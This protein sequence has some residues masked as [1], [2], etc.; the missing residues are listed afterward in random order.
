MSISR[1]STTG[2]AALVLLPD[3]WEPLSYELVLPL[4][5]PK[6]PMPGTAAGLRIDDI[7]K[8]AAIKTEDVMK[9]PMPASE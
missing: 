8:P 9:G 7:P 2:K 1:V 4:Q 3:G 6:P 5:C